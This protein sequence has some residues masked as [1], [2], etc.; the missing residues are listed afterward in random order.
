MRQ[1]LYAVPVLLIGLLSA[2]PSTL[3]G[4]SDTTQRIGRAVQDRLAAGERVRVVVELRRP[5]TVPG[6]QGAETARAA[7][8]HVQDRL[9]ERT[10]HSGTPRRLANL[11]VV[12]LEIDSTALPEL[13]SSPDVLSV[14]VDHRRRRNLAQSVPLIGAPTAWSLGLTGSGWAV[15]V[16]DS[17]VD[18]THPFLTGKVVSEACYSTSDVGG[19][20]TSLCPGG[21]D[22]TAVGSGVPCSASVEGCDH[23]THVAG[24]AA[25]TG[26][27]FSGVAKNASVIAIQVYSRIDDVAFC[28]PDPSPCVGAYDSDI[29]AGL[30]RVYA[31]RN[32]FNIAAASLS[33]G[34]DSFPGTCDAEN[35][36]YKTAI[37][38]LRS[39]KIATVISS[40]NDGFTNSIAAPACVSS[41]ISVGASDKSDQLAPYTNRSPILKLLAPGTGINA[42]VPGGGFATFNGTSSAAAHVAGAWALMRQS[43]PAADVTS[44]LTSLTST[45]VAIPDA[46]NGVT[47]PRINVGA[48]VSSGQ[49]FDLLLGRLPNFDG[50]FSGD[51]LW[52]S[53][54][55]GNYA[56]WLMNGGTM[57]GSSVFGAGTEWNL[58]GTG[59]LN[60]DGKADIIWRSATTGSL[61]IWFM[62]GGT[63]VNTAVFG[64]G[65]GWELLGRGDVNGDGK[66]DLLWYSPSTGN[67]AIWF[68]NGGAILNTHV[69]GVG[70]GW[71]LLGS[72]D[73]NGDGRADLIW[74]SEAA[75][76]LAVWFM[77]GSTVLSTAVFGVGAGWDLIASA[78]VNGDSRADFIWRS[79]TSGTVAVWLMNGGTVAGTAVF[80]VGTDWQIVG[81]GDLNTDSRADLLWRSTSTGTLA[82]WFLNGG[83][84]LNTS[85]FGVAGGWTVIGL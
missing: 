36:S 81:V 71:K 53:S 7:L 82:I 21:A 22:S 26:A 6:V 44:I 52:R 14:R 62:N 2:S 20:A 11:P 34:S 84:V 17:G 55:P 10:P 69:F 50:L 85:V 49:T 4:Q 23:G 67:F 45:A 32:T 3:A 66:V 31:L 48:A 19:N 46:A 79:P 60:G 37:D 61:A 29:L 72:G 43:N 77:N 51:I 18:K 73:V 64:V 30:D 1:R 27:T 38:L 35:P 57:V 78:D 42:P 25:G 59:D 28:S 9:L 54:T 56:M 16:L 33:L 74:R 15:A 58:A 24:I 63:T 13:S 39:A 65:T 76:T 80:G 12:A 8:A 83:T 40:G 41:A 5:L 68:M 75:G 70:A 47:R